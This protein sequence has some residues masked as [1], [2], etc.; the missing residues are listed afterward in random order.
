MI[1]TQ[2]NRW[3]IVIWFT[4]IVILG[5]VAQLGKWQIYNTSHISNNSCKC[6]NKLVLMLQQM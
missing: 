5:T 1:H 2:Q 4:I 6:K 3:F